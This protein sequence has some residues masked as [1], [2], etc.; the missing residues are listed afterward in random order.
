MSQMFAEFN[1]FC[2]VIF[3]LLC[4]SFTQPKFFSTSYYTS[5]YLGEYDHGIYI[6]EDHICDL[7]KFLQIT[8]FSYAWIIWDPEG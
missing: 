6:L 7:K 2:I 8:V 3:P 1:A 5:S 4:R